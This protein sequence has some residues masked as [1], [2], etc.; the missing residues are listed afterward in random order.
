MYDGPGRR[1]PDPYAATYVPQD[2]DQTMNAIRV[3]TSSTVDYVFGFMAGDDTSRDVVKEAVGTA[4]RTCIPG[5]TG[6][7]LPCLVSPCGPVPVDAEAGISIASRLVELNTA[8]SALNDGRLAI[9]QQLLGQLIG[10]DPGDPVTVSA[11]GF[12]GLAGTTVPLGVLADAGATVGSTDELLNSEIQLA[13]L[14]NAMASGATSSDSTVTANASS[15]LG[16]LAAEASP[17]GP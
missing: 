10:L 8:D 2:P 12:D 15:A 5:T 16:T 7:P 13:D 9:L 1:D 4:T 14:L 11:V 17:A 6:C 3:A